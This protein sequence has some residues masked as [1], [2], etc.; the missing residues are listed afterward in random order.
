MSYATNSLSMAGIF[1]L[2]MK[3]AISIELGN[4]EQ[5]AIFQS[6]R[7]YEKG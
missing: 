6:M 4:L 2:L 7:V 3:S 5:V 1:Y